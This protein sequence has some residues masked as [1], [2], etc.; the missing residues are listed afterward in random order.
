[1]LVFRHL[2]AVSAGLAITLIYGSSANAQELTS[3][4]K[5]HSEQ[6]ASHLLAS[7]QET[8]PSVITESQI[9]IPVIFSPT[10]KS[11][12]SV[13]RENK[14]TSE[15]N[16]E[17]NSSTILTSDTSVAQR[18]NLDSNS[19]KTSVVPLVIQTV[20][21]SSKDNVEESV[22]SN[23]LVIEVENMTN[24][25]TANESEIVTE[26]ISSE[27]EATTNES[28]IIT[29]SISS[30]SE[31][32][33]TERE[34]IFQASSPENEATTDESEIITESISSE[35]EETATERELIF[36]ASSPENEAT[37]DESE[38]VT[39][40]ISSESEETATERELI[41][42]ASSPENEATTDE[43][44]IITESIS[45]ES[46]ETA[47]ER[48]LIFQASSPENE[49]TTNEIEIITESISSE[50][51]ETAV[52]EELIFQ[53]PTENEA[54]TSES[55]IITESTS[56]ESEETAV[57]E[58]LIFQ[59]PTENEATTNE[60]EIVT[61]SIS[62]EN[63]ATTNE[64]EI[65]TESI[66]SESE[67]TAVEEELIFQKPT[68]NETITSESGVVT[69]TTS[70]ENRETNSETQSNSESQ[71]P[72]NQEINLETEVNSKPKPS[73]NQETTPESDS[74]SQPSENKQPDS[75]LEV[76]NIENLNP[77]PNP[78]VFPTQAD[79]VQVDKV[80]PITL[81]QAIELAQ[82]NNPDLQIAKL[83]L[84]RA[85]ESL[86][87]ALAAEYPILSTQVD[88]TRVD[89]AN[90][91]LSFARSA[92]FG[93]F[94]G[95]ADT[96][97]TTLDA[98][99]QLDYDLFTGGR[100]SAQINAARGQVKLNQLEV[101]RFSEQILFDATDAY[102]NLQ[103]SDAQVDIEKAAVRDATQ[104]LKDAEL[105]EQAGL[106]TKFDVL[107]AQVDL[108]DANQR[109]TRAIA[110][111]RIAKRQLVE[112]LNLGQQVELTAADAIE[113]A[114]SWDISLEETIVRAYKNRAEL[115]QLLV[116]R[117]IDDQERRIA[118][119]ASRPQVSLFA[120]YNV[121][122]ELDD[123]LAPADGFTLGA[124]LQWN[125]YDGGAANA[126]AEQETID[127]EVAE[128]RFSDQRNQ[129]RLEVETAFF[130]LQA[131]KDNIQTATIA[132]QLAQESLRLAR[133]RFQA[134]VGTQ[135]DVINAQSELTTARGNLLR[136]IIDY[137]RA[138]A[139]LQ[140]AV[141]NLDN[142]LFD[143]P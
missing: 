137:N 50:S 90:T 93:N 132:V 136:A 92:A 61:E 110:N 39:E 88:F 108:A 37:T 127:N 19:D 126:R 69:E 81:K 70:S 109:L 12:L 65:T 96:I 11:H 118:I 73:E 80:Q 105:L 97:T 143:L 35:S 94:S 123:N 14:S 64:S 112:V 31:E 18:E 34:L 134:G 114:G 13:L 115:E 62:S 16:I 104:T 87:E 86:R 43:S 120:N 79:E 52:E 103:D 7:S 48:E 77:S 72:E 51:E 44:E 27:N 2:I 36:Q 131:N 4:N 98:R 26:S 82:R 101:E 75:Q 28:E 42:Q 20:Q 113:V 89:S 66:S 138:L 6:E 129:I 111:Q 116:Q 47:T 41:F 130:N 55:E 84:E 45:S 141:T 60:S 124:R 33:A 99:L 17:I 117:D 76:T 32:T 133:L 128:T 74:D 122:G 119:A 21:D 63:E 67:E 107:R 135:T 142:Q 24:K 83:T 30:E 95:R 68:E 10:L 85:N 23:F 140:R 59:K 78:L 8:E 9:P 125:L 22:D 53:K 121:L 29:E 100:R 57:E 49:A 58:E 15:S 54:T 139:A 71:P 91:E 5:S 40:S 102:Y 56:S 1:M 38:V 46:E 106:G 25:E 3:L